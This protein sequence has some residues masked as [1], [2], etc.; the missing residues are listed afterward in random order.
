MVL[1]V[2]QFIFTAIASAVRGVAQDE[3]SLSAMRSANFFRAE[4]SPRRLIT[5]VFQIA[6]DCGESKRDMPFDVFKKTSSRSNCLDMSP[7]KGPQ[8]SR[9]V[10][11]FSVAGSGERLA[12]I[13]ASDELNAVSK[14][15]RWEGFK[16]RVN[17]CG[18]QFTRFHLCNQVCNGEGFDLHITHDAMSKP[19]K[20][21]SSFDSSVAGT[22]A[23]DGR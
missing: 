21:K 14:E 3:D 17:R 20:V 15:V 11:S 4:Y 1:G 19:G 12:R 6:D 16:I 22:K 23:D 2:A 5:I 8:V 7:D 18:T 13:T 10:G 9:V